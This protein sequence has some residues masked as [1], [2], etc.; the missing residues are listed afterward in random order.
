MFSQ[1]ST[2]APSSS[3]L[4]SSKDRFTVSSGLRPFF[5]SK[6]PGL[7]IKLVH[8]RTF[9]ELHEKFK[10]KSGAGGSYAG[11]PFTADEMKRLLDDRSL[12]L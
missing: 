6:N 3:S 9:H 11:T 10:L 7:T 8:W 12:R 4:F 2:L 1:D 5:S